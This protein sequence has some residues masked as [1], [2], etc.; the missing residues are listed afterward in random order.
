MILRIIYKIWTYFWRIFFT[1]AGLLLLILTI[2]VGLLQLPQSK[3]YISNEFQELFNSQFEGEL[4]IERISGFL[5]FQMTLHSGEVYAP[6]DSVNAR[7]LFDKTT[8]HVNWWD[9]IQRDL[10]ISS[11]SIDEPLIRLDY[12]D[13]ELV[14]A[15]AF[16]NRSGEESDPLNVSIEP[17]LLKQMRFYAPSIIINGG[18]AELDE[19]VIL[20]EQLDIQT[21]YTIQNLDLS[22][23][24]ELS[25]SLVFFDLSHLTADLPGTPFEQIRFS[26]QFYNDDEYFELNRFRVGTAI[27][28]ADFSFEATP[29]SLFKP[30]FKDQFKNAAFQLHITESSFTSGLIRQFTSAYPDFNE[31]LELELDSEGTFENFFIDKLQ[32]NVGESSI[33]FSGELK[34]LLEGPLEYDANLDNMVIH[35]STMEWIS[36]TYL[37]ADVNLERYQLSTVRG[38]LNGDQNQLNSNIRVETEAGALALEGNLLFDDQ[39]IYDLIFNVDTLDVTPF[40]ADTLNSSIIQGRLTLAGSGTGESAIFQSTI[41]LSQSILIGHDLNEF[42][43]NI[44]YNKNFW[45]FN[46]QSRDDDQFFVEANGSYGTENGMTSLSSDGVV[47]N[48]NL[49]KFIPDYSAG[50]T[51][52]NSTFS[53]NL[54]W[55]T[56]DD[57]SGRVSL[58]ISESSIAGEELRPH[59]FYA[60]LND[61]GNDTRTLRF[62]SSFFDGELRGSIFPS[63][64]R[65]S[66]DYWH[67]YFDDRVGSE[68]LFTDQVSEESDQR[69]SSQSDLLHADLNVQLT[70]K[71]ISLLRRYFPDLPDIESNVRL[72]SSI[73]STPERL[74]ITGSFFEEFFKFDNKEIENLNS[75]FTA[76]FR[77]DRKFRESSTLDLQLNSTGSL[78]G[79]HQFKESH[80][81]LSV[82]DDS[83]RIQTAVER[84]DDE[85]R[86]E[87]TLTGYLRDGELELLLDKF[88][89]GD[90][91]YQWSSQG[92]PLLRYNRERELL[93]DNLI[94][95]SGNEYLEINGTYSSDPDKFVEYQ[96]ENFELSRLSNII[97]GRIRFSGNM[98]GNFMTRTLTEIPVIQ[99]NIFVDQG[100][101]MDRVIGDVT[102]NSSFN[103]E[104]NLFDTEIHVFTDPEK[105]SRYYNRNDEIGQ[106]IY[107]SGFFRLPDDETGP[108]EDLFYFDVDLREIDM[109]IVTFIIPNIVTDMEGRSSGTGFIRLNQNGI[110][111]ASNFKIENV[112]GVPL[113]TNVPYNLSGELDFTMDDGL[114]FRDI[115]LTDHRGGTGV[116]SGQV[117]LDRFS[118]LTILNLTLDLNNLH[119]MNNSF[120]PDVPFYGAIYGTGQAQISGNNNQ[121][122]LRTTRPLIISPDSEISIPLE[123][124]TE[125]E[126][127]RRFIEFVES[128]DISFWDSQLTALRRSENGNGDP[129]EL[130]FL[131]LFTMD[132]Q[133][134]AN[135]PTNIRLIF[136][137]VTND[138][139]NASG[140]GQVRIL[141]EDQDVSMFGRFNITEGDYQFV[142]GDIFTRR[143]TIQ[144]GGTISWSGDLVDAALN[145][146]AVYRARPNI[147]TLLSGT[148]SSAFIDPNLRI[149]IELVLQI[150]GSISAVENEFFFRV[151]SGIESSADPTIASQISN[152]NQNED[153][154]LIQATS[155]LLSG[156]FLPM[157][158]AQGLGIAENLTGTAVVNPLITSQVI[159]PLLSNQIN[160]LLRSDITFDIDLN[161]TTTNEVDLGVA[162]RL[163]DD[164]IVLRREGQI[165]GEQSDI[166][167]LGATYRINRAL[168]VTAFHRQDPTL[169]YTSGIDTRQTQEMNGIGLEAQIQFNTWQ[170]LRARLSNA[171]RSL[172]GIKEDEPVTNES[173]LIGAFE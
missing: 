48:L 17:G 3:I 19:S 137:R 109:W 127:D 122:I 36:N 43:A 153:Q 132:L 166:G 53:G 171:F 20:P 156:N 115:Q 55:S 158:Q 22:I 73:N 25:E 157:E 31:R 68:I 58:E 80:F 148:G 61:T 67:D 57:L 87:S 155:I 66:F 146:T 5:P 52:L 104:T 18:Q 150:G 51:S 2:L 29:V 169:A 72:N 15:T 46:I 101:I 102:L 94:I 1:L 30:L 71:D 62:T 85:L 69:F 119:F 38:S 91:E 140:T 78:F 116:L 142:S 160:S 162:L 50:E 170:S 167:D 161:L 90:P 96:I 74:L 117:D 113:F 23:F 106:D 9:L 40:L 159:N 27:G 144:D 42:I 108:D 14:L 37:E 4:K 149:P 136:D 168:S 83:V 118:P 133:F 6:S 98:N 143:F 173:E 79:K 26:G 164:R 86:L 121:P 56:I 95:T 33:L 11:F 47:R 151:P 125:F 110:D 10:T 12:K 100:R 124:V 107:L 24:L 8:I 139:L 134:Q 128:F 32:A 54:Q 92:R 49:L 120:D 93:V 145:V 16:R 60:D 135:D 103:S 152:L 165:T 138:I 82:R 89:L 35:P 163:F 59:Q 75:V 76:S 45:N 126:Q 65:S 34:Q 63:R 130:T 13:D 123:P 21:P 28:N 44:D 84:L 131:Q 141:L 99:G 129:E 64:L 105:Y 88:T 97:D 81:N 7:L 77:S 41:Y 172:F 147:S 114:L 112:H 70:V 39:L 111:F 154:K